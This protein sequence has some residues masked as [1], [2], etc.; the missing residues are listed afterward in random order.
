MDFFTRR[1]PHCRALIVAATEAQQ[2][3]LRMICMDLSQRCDW[4]RGSG[5]H[6]DYKKW[7]QL[8]V[9]AWAR[10]HDAEAGEILPSIDESGFDIVYLRP[11]RLPKLN[12][13]EL[14][15]FADAWAAE[16]GVT[17]TPSRRDRLLEQF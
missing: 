11:E 5:H 12:M 16:H 6:L 17:R 4:P 13:T 8:L 1:C 15:A 10:A 7:K 9:L 14:L 3:A 2:L